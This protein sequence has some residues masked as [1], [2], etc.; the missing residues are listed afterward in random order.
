MF[1]TSNSRGAKFLQFIVTSVIGYPVCRLNFYPSKQVLHMD[2][3]DYYGGESTSL[4]LNQ[5][6][7]Y[8]FCIVK[9]CSNLSLFFL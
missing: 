5:V 6:K 2:K 9:F 3:N 1:S 7:L 8:L 4:N